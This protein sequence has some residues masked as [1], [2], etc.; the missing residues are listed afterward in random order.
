[1]ETEIMTIKAVAEYLKITENPAYRLAGD[2]R[3]PGFKVGGAWWFRQSEVEAWMDRQSA[4]RKEG[5]G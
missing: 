1:M 5:G 2:G 4:E 3:I